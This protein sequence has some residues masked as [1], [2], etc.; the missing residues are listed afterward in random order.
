MYYPA[1]VPSPE[2]AMERVRVQRWPKVSTR[3]RR[4][5]AG[6][7]GQGVGLANDRVHDR[8]D[9]VA[10]AGLRGHLGDAVK[11]NIRV[12]GR[13]Q[14]ESAARTRLAIGRRGRLPSPRRQQRFLKMVERM[15]SG[16]SMV[17]PSAFPPDSQRLPGRHQQAI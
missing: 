17:R 16:P 6:F 12:R 14:L 9:L 13:S 5:Q 10:P 7:P 3:Y 15:Y 8:H 1:M 11:D 2:E 4:G